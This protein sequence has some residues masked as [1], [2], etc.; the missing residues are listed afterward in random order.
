MDNLLKNKLA[1]SQVAEWSTHKLVNSSK[2]LMENLE[3]MICLS[4]IVAK[5]HYVYTINI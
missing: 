4:V 3:Y 1:V 5:L 2:Y